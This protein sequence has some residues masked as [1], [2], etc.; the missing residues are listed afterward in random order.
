M[1]LVVALFVAF[2]TVL[3]IVASFP[4]AIGLPARSEGPKTHQPAGCFRCGI[5]P[6]FGSLV[7]F[8]RH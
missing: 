2:L 4:D 8:S 7:D 3:A 5:W 6:F 1:P